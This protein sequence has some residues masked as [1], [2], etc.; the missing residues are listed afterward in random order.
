VW[1]RSDRQGR[2]IVLPPTSDED[3]GDRGIDRDHIVA[4]P[5]TLS[6]ETEGLYWVTLE[7]R[8]ETVLTSN[9]V[10]LLLQSPARAARVA[11]AARTPRPPA[12]PWYAWILAPVG[13]SR[14][15]AMLAVLVLVALAWLG[16]GFYEQRLSADTSSGTGTT[17]SPVETLPGPSGPTAA[18]GTTGATG[19]TGTTRTGGTSGTS[20]TGATTPITPTTSITPSSST[21]TAAG[22]PVVA[23]TAPPPFTVPG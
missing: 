2:Q 13:I 14:L 18:T 21:T 10:Q 20:G 6:P 9:T 5:I 23:R 17:P 12:A 7:G 19:A 4:R 15:L 8:D 3:G 22:V 11:Q 16:R 1:H